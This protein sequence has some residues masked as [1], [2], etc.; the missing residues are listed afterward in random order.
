[1]EPHWAGQTLSILPDGASPQITCPA[2]PTLPLPF[3]WKMKALCVCAM[4]L[5]LSWS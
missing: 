4:A 2:C 5:P 1:M 3:P